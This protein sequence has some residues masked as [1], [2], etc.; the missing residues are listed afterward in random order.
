MEGVIK[1]KNEPL[2]AKLA[3]TVVTIDGIETDEL[4]LVKEIC[5]NALTDIIEDIHNIDLTLTYSELIT[6]YIMKYCLKNNIFT[7]SSITEAILTILM[8]EP[9]GKEILEYL[10]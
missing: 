1:M 6:K 8:S 2:L 3:L 9:S 7:P 10:L 5:I 4:K